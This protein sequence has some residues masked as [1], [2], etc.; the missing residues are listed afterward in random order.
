[1][2]HVLGGA[3]VRQK[4]YDLA[5]VVVMENHF[6]SIVV[7]NTETVK[8]CVDYLKEQKWHPMTFLPLESISVKPPEQRSALPCASV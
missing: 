4:R 5:M 1:V 8:K 6:D 3:Q 2:W 7:D